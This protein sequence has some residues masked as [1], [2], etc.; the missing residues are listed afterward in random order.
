[1]NQKGK[2]I[3]QAKR[4]LER[5]EDGPAEKLIQA[6]GRRGEKGGDR[7]SKGYQESDN[8]GSCD[9]RIWWNL[10]ILVTR[11]DIASGECMPQ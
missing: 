8:R 10:R 1:M 9:R 2:S 5:Q 3:E 11:L 7:H 6:K 4:Q